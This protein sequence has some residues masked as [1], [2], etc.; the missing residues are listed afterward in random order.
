MSG[1]ILNAAIGMA[2]DLVKEAQQ[3]LEKNYGLKPSP[4]NIEATMQLATIYALIFQSCM[5]NLKD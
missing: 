1:P 5:S 3:S 4:D 2:E